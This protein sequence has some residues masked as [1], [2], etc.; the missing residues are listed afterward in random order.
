M[1]KE[2]FYA[3][4]SARSVIA[5]T[6]FIVGGCTSRYDGINMDWCN[7]PSFHKLLSSKKLF[8]IFPMDNNFSTNNGIIGEEARLNINAM[9]KGIF[10]LLLMRCA[11]LPEQIAE[12]ITECI[13]DWRDKDREPRRYGAEDTYYLS[14]PYQY[15]ASDCEFKSVYDLLFV[16]GM[17]WE[18]FY[19]IEP[20]ITVFG[21]GKININS[22]SE[23][24]LRVIAEYHAAEN[25]KNIIDSLLKKVLYFRSCCGGFT[26]ENGDFIVSSL[27]KKCSL[28]QE[29]KILFYKMLNSFTISSSFFRG[30]ARGYCDTTRIKEYEFVF[31]RKTGKIFVMRER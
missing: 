24:V 6:I 22:A 10:M 4:V 18:I 19:K 14:L 29:E 11:E 12:E 23:P 1:L 8:Y 28:S 7:S 31:E 26:V 5:E 17:K 30:I 2:R 27:D 13:L 9:D 21:T 25:K 3:D 16:K 15:E 20:Y